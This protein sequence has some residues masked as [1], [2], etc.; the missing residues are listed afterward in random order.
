MAQEG[1]IVQSVSRTTIDVYKLLKSPTKL[2]I[3]ILTHYLVL[4]Q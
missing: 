4:L 3:Y 1:L 2:T